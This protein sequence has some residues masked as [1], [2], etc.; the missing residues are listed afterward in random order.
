MTCASCATRVEKKL[1]KL[2]GVTASV[3]YATEKAKVTCPA[4]VTEAELVATVERTGYT[5]RLP[6]VGRTDDAPARTTPSADRWPPCAPGC[7]SRSLLTVPVV[8]MAMVPALQFTSW[9]WASLD[10]GGAGRRLGRAGRSTARRGPTCG[11]P[12][13]PWTPSSRSARSPPSAGRSTR[14]SSAPRASPGMTHPFRLALERSDGGG[15]IYLEVA[16][17]VTTFILAG[18]VCRDSAPSA[19]PAPPCG[20][21]SRPA[22]RRWRCCGPGPTATR[23]ERVPV[24]RLGGRRPLRRAPRRE[25]RHRRH[26]RVG[27]VGRRRVA[28]HRR[29]GAGRGRPPVTLV[30]GVDGQRRRPPRRAGHPGRCR[31]PARADGPARRGRPERQGRRCSGWPTGCPASSSPSSSCWPWRRSASGSAPAPAGRPPSR[32]RW[33]C[34]SSP[35]R[36]PSGWPR[37]PRSWSAPAAGPSSGCSSAV[38]RCWSRPGRSTPC[39]W[40]RPARSR[41]GG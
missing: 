19:R 39:C 34:S 13:P 8:A 36:A 6:E 20:R 3:N 25:G 15:N 29:V 7:S 26:G 28:R 10:A 33:P 1:N 23:E 2:D 21:C 38:P 5:A 11:T 17:G 16:A 22:P 12:R 30:V 31:H 40:T 35:A 32:P 4:P 37:R 41:P 27:L 18:P 9:Q 14:C 24:E